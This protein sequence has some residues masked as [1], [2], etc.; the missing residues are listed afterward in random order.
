MRKRKEEVEDMAISFT[1]TKHLKEVCKMAQNW[2]LEIN[3]VSFGDHPEKID[4]RAW[5]PDKTKMGKGLRLNGMDELFALGDA[6]EAIRKEY[7]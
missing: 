3:K 7:K 4:I 6:I 1:I 5:N 2:S